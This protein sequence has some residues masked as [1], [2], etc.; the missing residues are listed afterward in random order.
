MTSAP[1]F[2]GHAESYES[3][4]ARG[5]SLAGEDR[6][7]FAR[8]RVEFLSRALRD[9]PGEPCAPGAILDFG[10]GLGG[11][12]RLLE[13]AFPGAQVLGVDPSPEMVVRAREKCQGPRSRFEVLEGHGTWSAELDLIYMA[14]VLHHVF[15]G[16][17][18]ALLVS[19]ARA[20]RPGGS[21]AIFENN[22]WNPG[23][24]AVMARVPFDRDAIPLSVL[25]VRRRVR[26]AG[27]EIVRVRS[28][29]YFP[30]VLAWLRALEPA[31]GRAPLGA[32]HF[33]LARRRPG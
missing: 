30:R 7:H 8:R 18:D 16:D 1:L 5:L 28:L 27:L 31:L 26:Q 9:L 6:E 15:P 19:L 29:F 17:R 11:T 13:A 25:E 20:L 32:Q 2:D 24:R 4:V 23:A 33:V 14:N 12:A 21:L 10:C 22:P 3:Q